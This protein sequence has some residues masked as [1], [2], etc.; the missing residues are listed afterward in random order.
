M[1]LRSTVRQFLEVVPPNSRGYRPDIDGLRALAVLAVIAYHYAPSRFPGG[2]IGV[3]VFFVI[4]GYLITGI[5]ARHFET[6]SFGQELLDFYQRRIRRIFPALSLILLFCL[7]IGW[8]ALFASEYETLGKHVAAGAGFVQNIALWQEAGYFDAAAIQKPL[9]HLWSLAVEEQFYIFWPLVLWF[10]TRRRW[11]LLAS[12][13]VIAGLS[14]ALNIWGVSTQHATTSFYLPVTR[15]WELMAGAWLAIGHK[16]HITWLK[17][18]IP[19][20]S[21]LGLALIV[22]GFVLIRPDR[23]FPGYWAV[24]PVIGAAFIINAGANTFPNRCLLSLRPVV[25][26]GL[27][28]YP[29][30]LWHWSLL[31]LTMNAFGDGAS[32]SQLY[33]YKAFALAISFALAHLTY[34]WMEQPIRR[35]GRKKA[36]IA[37]A[38]ALLTLGLAGLFIYTTDGAPQR[39]FTFVSAKASRYIASI[40]RSPLTHS[41]FD[42]ITGATLSERWSCTVGDKKAKTWIAAYGD[43]HALSLLPALN[44]YGKAENIRVVFAGISSCPPLLRT[45]SEK[46]SGRACM[47]LSRKMTDLVEAQ[48]ASAVVL[49]AMWPNFTDPASASNFVYQSTNTASS[50]EAHGLS[51]LKK[52]LHATLSYFD[53]LNIPVL[54]VEDN[55]QQTVSLPRGIVRFG[56]RSDSAFNRLAVSLTTHRHD[57]QAVNQVLEAAAAK[58]PMTF[59]LNT[60]SVLCSDSI[61]PWV[62]DGRFLYFDSNHLSITG[63]MKVYPLLANRLNMLLTPSYEK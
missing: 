59:I 18:W 1:T 32:S 62:S 35:T 28:S 17:H 41:C 19:A 54:L 56:Y 9:L 22:A 40:Q 51:A 38:A 42:L 37:F 5:L 20:Q 27:I 23:D 12:I 13:T 14:F 4:S 58:H 25:W 48:R 24:L 53:R 55:P 2:F 49:I 33:W 43:S 29:L 61:C 47:A 16:Q 57:Q 44:R 52:G 11:P 30:Y 46:L 50:T 63:A 26:V 45:H 6:R 60:D 3:D 39:P 7:V 10:I 36:T 21:W 31:S 34:H 15:A 8:S